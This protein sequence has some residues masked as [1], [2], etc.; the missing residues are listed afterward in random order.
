MDSA[1]ASSS[2]LS[3]SKMRS[4]LAVTHYISHI[5]VIVP[6]SS[7]RLLT[8]RASLIS[9]LLP[10]IVCRIVAGLAGCG[11]TIS[12]QQNFDGLHVWDRGAG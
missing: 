9:W 12:V 3:R 2:N 7:N 10:S 1:N 6:L 4:G 11:K 8:L 5:L